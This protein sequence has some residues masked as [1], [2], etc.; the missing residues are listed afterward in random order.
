MTSWL[1]LQIAFSLLSCAPDGKVVVESDFSTGGGQ[2]KPQEQ[3]TA[4]S[5][6]DTA[7]ST[8]PDT[9]AT[10]PDTGAASEDTGS[11]EDTDLEPPEDSGSAEGCYTGTVT[12]VVYE[13]MADF[14][15]A[16]GTDMA[17]IDFDDVDT[18]AEDPVSI[19]TDHY[20]SSHGATITGEGGQ[21]VD[22]SFRWSD[23]SSVSSPNMYAPG[24]A[25]EE[26][27]GFNTDVAFEAGGE[28]ACVRGFG[29]VYIDA[30]FPELGESSLTVYGTDR[31]SLHSE[32][33][34]S[35]ESAASLFRGM[36]A[37]DAEGSSQP[38]IGSVHLV[39][40]SAWPMSSCCDGVT[41]DDFVFSPPE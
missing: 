33:G 36:V 23:Y 7:G 14:E 29:A 12:I 39:N 37:F 26:A 15:A 13:S 6:T 1:P 4:T 11:F 24:P 35:S 21:Y 34:F 31:T 22:E 38:A 28:D 30:D 40:G 32:S 16:L 25:I 20:L 17:K 3:D 2:S 41:L 8:Q 5:S 27:G 10:G 9:G 19:D 18:S